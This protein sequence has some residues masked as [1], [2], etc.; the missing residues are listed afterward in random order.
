MDDQSELG[1][2]ADVPIN[3]LL[4]FK[5]EMDWVFFTEPQSYGSLSTTEQVCTL[6]VI[7]PSVNSISFRASACGAGAKYKIL[8]NTFSTFQH[9][10][11]RTTNTRSQ[12]SQSGRTTES[13]QDLLTLTFCGFVAASQCTAL[14]HALRDFTSGITD[15][16]HSYMYFDDSRI[17]DFRKAIGRGERSLEVPACSMQCNGS[18]ATDTT[19]TIGRRAGRRAGATLTC[20]PTSR[21]WRIS[22]LQWMLKVIHQTV[23]SVLFVRSELDVIPHTHCLEVA[24]FV[25]LLQTK[26]TMDTMVR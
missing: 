22:D 21:E 23:F 25:F 18:G 9:W 6:S 1:E 4:N 8:E 13:T 11:W 5:T 24:F 16:E 17:Y 3:Y 7:L 14:V 2:Q 19:T 12:S 15:S 20:C 26:S 10:P